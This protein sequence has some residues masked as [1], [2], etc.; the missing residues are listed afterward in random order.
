MNA[1]TRAKAL[2]RSIQADL[3]MAGRKLDV[4]SAR[5]RVA[6]GRLRGASLVRLRKL[7]VKQAQ[8]KVA[9]GKLARRSDAARGEAK[10]AVRAALRDIDA[11]IARATR[12]LRAS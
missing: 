4:V 2:L 12:R 11:A 10:S 8:A 7:K 5:A 3:R 6:E 9:L 1:E